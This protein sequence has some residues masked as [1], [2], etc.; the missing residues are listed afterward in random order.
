MNRSL[1]RALVEGSRSRRGNS[2]AISKPLFI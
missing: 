2:A 1:I